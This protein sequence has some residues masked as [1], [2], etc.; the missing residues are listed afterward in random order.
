MRIRA[1]VTDNQKQKRRSE[2]KVRKSWPAQV[3]EHST[4]VSW[5]R[6]SSPPIVLVLVLVLDLDGCRSKRL[7]TSASL[8]RRAAGKC[9]GDDIAGQDNPGS[10]GSDG[11]SPYLSAS[12]F[13][14]AARRT[15][16]SSFSPTFSSS[17]ESKLNSPF[18]IR[19]LLSR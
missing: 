5:P 9:M 19:R 16:I 7:V 3:R 17:P 2:L 4:A 6:L 15:N 8:G 10:P 18:S 11:A 1:Q 12:R 14:G 13:S